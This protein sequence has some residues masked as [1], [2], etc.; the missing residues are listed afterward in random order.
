M[1]ARFTLEMTVGEVRALLP[2]LV[3]EGVDCPCCEARVRAYRR[4]LTNTAARA[5]AALLEEHGREYGHMAQVARKHL[6]DVAA[7][8]GYLVLGQ[9][10]GLIE[11]EPQVRGDRGRTGFWRVTDLGEAW[12]A[13]ESAIPKY[14]R[15]FHGRCLALEGDL[16]R[17]EDVLGEH[18]DFARLMADRAPAG[19]PLSLFEEAA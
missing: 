19:V 7:Q 15:L 12:L 8:G 2:G 3:V 10:W 1:T 17:R 9:H 16:V 4:A 14:A 18:F 13:G 6:P 11:S 5:V